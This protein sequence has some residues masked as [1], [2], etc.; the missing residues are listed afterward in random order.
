MHAPLARRWKSERITSNESKTTRKRGVHRI[1]IPS[2][3][4]ILRRDQTASDSERS[5]R[6]DSSANRYRSAPGHWCTPGS[7]WWGGRVGGCW[8]LAGQ[9]ELTAPSEMSTDAV[10][11]AAGRAARAGTRLVRGVVSSRA[12]VLGRVG[13]RDTLCPRRH[14]AGRAS[15]SPPSARCHRR[16]PALGASARPGETVMRRRHAHHVTR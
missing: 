14:R 9:Q 15:A 8:A 2:E 6:Q 16:E 10:E 11:T 4:T 7:S 1:L 3:S 5:D 12:L 13:G